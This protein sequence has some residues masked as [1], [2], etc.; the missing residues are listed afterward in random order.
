MYSTVFERNENAKLS[1]HTNAL[2][3]TRQSIFLYIIQNT[4]PLSH[5]ICKTN[6]QIK[7]KETKIYLISNKTDNTQPKAS[8]KWEKQI[9]KLTL[10]GVEKKKQ[11]ARTTTQNRKSNIVFE[12]NGMGKTASI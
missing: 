9:K 7:K 3:H 8:S 2:M 1:T 12:M 6:D 11:M 5:Y 4:Q 10:N